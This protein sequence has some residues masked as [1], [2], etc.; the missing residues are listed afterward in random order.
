M[1]KLL[2][3]RNIQTE[4]VSSDLREIQM[5]R[6][7]FRRYSLNMKLITTKYRQKCLLLQEAAD[8]KTERGK[9]TRTPRVHFTNKQLI[10]ELH[11]YSETD[12]GTNQ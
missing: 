10:T 3:E 4:A 2:R 12:A 9:S 7:G 1:S 11:V 8:R 5:S 6:A